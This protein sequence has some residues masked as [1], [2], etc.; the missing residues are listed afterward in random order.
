[1]ADNEE[2]PPILRGCVIVVQGSAGKIYQFRSNGFDRDWKP[3]YPTHGDPMFA[4]RR[5][6][7]GGR[8]GSLLWHLPTQ[9]VQLIALM[10]Y[11]YPQEINLGQSGVL[12][13]C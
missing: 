11:G 3:G 8:P 6:F 7:A 10:L 1:M 2:I 12:C 9:I 4:M 5:F 13:F